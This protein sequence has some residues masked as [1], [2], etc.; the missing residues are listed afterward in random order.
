MLSHEDETLLCRNSIR[1]CRPVLNWDF[2]IHGS[3]VQPTLSRLFLS[4]VLWLRFNLS[5]TNGSLNS[6]KACTVP[7]PNSPLVCP[8]TFPKA[9]P[10]KFWILRATRTHVRCIISDMPTNVRVS[11]C[12]FFSGTT[13]GTVLPR[14]FS[15]KVFR[16]PICP[17]SLCDFI[18][19]EKLQWHPF[20]LR[21]PSRVSRAAF[22]WI[23]FG[24]VW[25]PLSSVTKIDFGLGFHIHKVLPMVPN[26]S[27]WTWRTMS[28]NLSRSVSKMDWPSLCTM[29]DPFN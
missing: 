12:K 27:L 28:C 29:K 3:T 9:C 1:N 22:A 14:S 20:T 21:V 16:G 24:L 19:F 23:M 7:C 13:D 6:S 11:R 5:N 2:R 26:W 4:K 10:I 17:R 25:A 18:P 15:P 8:S